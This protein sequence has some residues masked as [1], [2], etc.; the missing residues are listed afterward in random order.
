MNWC[1]SQED[2]S[3]GNLSWNY[4]KVT[5]YVKNTKTTITYI[6]HK[7]IPQNPKS[8][9]NFLKLLKMHSRLDLRHFLAPK[10]PLKIMKNAFYITLKALSILRISKFCLLFLVIHKKIAWSERKGKF[11]NLW[12]HSLVNKQSKYTY[13]PI[14]QEVKKTRH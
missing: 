3:F 11:P 13:C 2:T 6:Y 1:L 9:N 4:K 14:S 8:L 7:Y 10:S 12:C 5:K